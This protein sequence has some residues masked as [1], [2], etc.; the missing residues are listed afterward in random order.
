M[1]TLKDVK[2]NSD[3]KHMIEQANR[4]LSEK[5]YTEHGFRHVNYV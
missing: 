1:L 5:G 4:Y 2:E 3:F